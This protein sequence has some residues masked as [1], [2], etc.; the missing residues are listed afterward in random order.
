MKKYTNTNNIKENSFIKV[1]WI[2]HA[3]EG[4]CDSLQ[5]TNKNIFRYQSA[6]F[7]KALFLLF[8]HMKDRKKNKSQFAAAFVGIKVTII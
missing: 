1:Y 6:N 7:L 8:V 2:R 3:F 4:E 5:T